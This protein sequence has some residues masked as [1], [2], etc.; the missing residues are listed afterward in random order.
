MKVGGTCRI[1]LLDQQHLS[2]LQRP[3]FET[4]FAILDQS[5]MELYSGRRS[6]LK[7]ALLE[8]R[9]SLAPS[10]QGRVWMTNAQNIPPQVLIKIAPCLIR[11]LSPSSH[12][13]RFK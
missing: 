6:L 7:S 2:G 1:K 5:Y 9:S 10:E 11:D 4:S 8:E 13:L 3:A 12:R